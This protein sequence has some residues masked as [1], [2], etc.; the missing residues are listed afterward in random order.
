[1]PLPRIAP[2]RAQKIADANAVEFV[3][4]SVLTG[5][6][7]GAAAAVGAPVHALAT[8]AAAQRLEHAIP[9]REK[10]LLQSTALVDPATARHALDSREGRIRWL[11]SIIDGTRKTDGPFGQPRMYSAADQMRALAMLQKTCGDYIE[12][13]EV[14]HTDQ[15][16]ITVFHLPSNDRVPD[17]VIVE[18]P[19]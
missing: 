9:E 8:N 11:Q 7:E 14:T 10:E 15:Q 4:R 3:K 17:E 1:M 19:E 13:V 6:P 12:R 5:D 2:Y 16:I 18:M